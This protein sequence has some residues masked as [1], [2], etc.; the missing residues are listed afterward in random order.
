M[1]WYQLINL[2]PMQPATRNQ[3]LNSCNLC[4]SRFYNPLELPDHMV[5]QRGHFVVSQGIADHPFCSFREGFAL[6]LPGGKVLVAEYGRRKLQLA[7]EIVNRELIFQKISLG[8]NPPNA[9]MGQGIV[10]D[11]KPG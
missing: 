4:V 1:L 5:F 9:V 6:L 3:R 8:A 7:A 11:V 10:V 2:G